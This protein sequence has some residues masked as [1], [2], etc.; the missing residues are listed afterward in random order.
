MKKTIVIREDE[1]DIEIPVKA[2]M[3]ALA[4]YR[5]EF[6][7]DLIKDLNTVYQEL[8]PDPFAAA[9]KKINYNPDEMDQDKLAAL[10]MANV[11]YQQLSEQERLPDETAV[12]KTLQILW[13]MAKAADKRIENFD[14]WS[15]EFDMIPVKGLIERCNEIWTA[16]NMTTVELKN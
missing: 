2:N 3:A 16:A 14:D 9:M 7:G 12:T 11:D 15:E 1:K 5:E 10:L 4:I 8:H 13:S 6:T